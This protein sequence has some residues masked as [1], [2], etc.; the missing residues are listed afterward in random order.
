MM[1]V[2][3]IYI[4]IKTNKHN[5]GIRRT[6]F[7]D[8]RYVASGTLVHHYLCKS[9]PFVDLYLFYLRFKFGH[10]DFLFGVRNDFFK[11]ATKYK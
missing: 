5:L 9:Q 6:D 3:P 1:D 10:T 4:I 7:K 2:I 8:S 11:T